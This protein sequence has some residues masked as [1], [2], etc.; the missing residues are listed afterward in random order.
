[1]E[2]FFPGYEIGGVR[3]EKNTANNVMK[4]RIHFILFIAKRVKNGPKY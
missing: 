1:M 3:L 2:I 4:Y